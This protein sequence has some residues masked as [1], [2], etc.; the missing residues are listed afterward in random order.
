MVDRDSKTDTAVERL[1]WRGGKFVAAPDPEPSMQWMDYKWALRARKL[2]GKAYQLASA[3]A[4]LA[5]LRG[6][7]TVTPSKRVLED[8]GIGKWALRDGLKTLELAEFVSVDRGNGRLPRVT[9]LDYQLRSG[10]GK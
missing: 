2:P 5:K 4:L 9:L 1:V 6:D 10:N 3:L 7:T 8:F